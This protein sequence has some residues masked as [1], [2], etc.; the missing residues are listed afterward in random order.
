VLVDQYAAAFENADVTALV[1]LLRADAV[2]EMPPVPTWFAG[3]D[4][5][6]RFLA[7]RVLREPGGLRMIPT[8]ANG[9]PALAAYQRGNDGR[10]RAYVVQVLTCTTAGVARVVAFRDPGLFARFGLPPELPV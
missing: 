9:Q 3:R 6:G 1:R 10:Y 5:I 8:G 4:Q 7:A 2:F